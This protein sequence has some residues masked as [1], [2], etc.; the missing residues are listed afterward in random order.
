MPSFYGYNNEA[1]LRASN[2]QSADEI[3]GKATRR[4]VNVCSRG[5]TCVGSVDGRTYLYSD[6]SQDEG[7]METQ[8]RAEHLGNVYM[9]HE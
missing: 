6:G 3:I 7:V 4:R 1:E 9:W 2:P 8:C 5:K